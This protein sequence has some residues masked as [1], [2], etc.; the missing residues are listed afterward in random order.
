MSESLKDIRCALATIKGRI[1]EAEQEKGEHHHYLCGLHYG[2][3]VLVM[4][5]RWENRREESA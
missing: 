3:G 5:E 2:K 1:K 4:L